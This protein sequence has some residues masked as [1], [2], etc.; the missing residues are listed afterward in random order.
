MR[1]GTQTV[2]VYKPLKDIAGTAA[3][4]AV[5]LVRGR[6]PQFNATL[7]NGQKDVPSTFLT[8]ILVTKQNWDLVVK[9]G[10]YTEAQIA[11]K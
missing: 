2:T 5:A 7:N 11:R 4:L 9:D 8:P 10:F 1:A 3:E 6:S